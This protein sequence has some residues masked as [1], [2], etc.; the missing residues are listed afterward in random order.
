MISQFCNASLFLS[1]SAVPLRPTYCYICLGRYFTKPS[2][3][4]LSVETTLG[5]TSNTSNILVIT[6]NHRMSSKSLLYKH[7]VQLVHNSSIFQFRLINGNYEITLEF[8]L[9][10]CNSKAVSDRIIQ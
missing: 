4:L 8:L 1:F 10:S 6:L 2:Q 3:N 5:V 7:G 9:P